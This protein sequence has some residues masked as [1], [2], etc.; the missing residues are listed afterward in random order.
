MGAVTGV[1]NRLR[2]WI[3]LPQARRKLMRKKEGPVRKRTT[4]GLYIRLG[5]RYLQERASTIMPRFGENRGG[6]V[7]GNGGPIAGYD[8]E[9]GV[10]SP[11]AS[12]ADPP[13]STGHY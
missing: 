4:S 12:S 10:G 1:L 8:S 9:R 5:G 6:F 3:D 2:Y 11:M 13:V 7:R